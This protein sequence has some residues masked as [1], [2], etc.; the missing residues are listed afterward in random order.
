[1]KRAEVESF[2]EEIRF[3]ESGQE[4]HKRSRIKSVDLRMEGGSLVVGG[5]L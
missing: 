4:V 2:G 3:L 5:R 1:M